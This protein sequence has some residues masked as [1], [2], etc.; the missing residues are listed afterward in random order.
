MID[1]LNKFRGNENHVSNVNLR[2]GYA[3]EGFSINWED[4]DQVFQALYSIN[5][6]LMLKA[7]FEL[8]KEPESIDLFAG[9]IPNLIN[10]MINFSN[11][12]IEYYSDLANRIIVNIFV[13]HKDEPLYHGKSCAY[14]YLNDLIQ[15][16]DGIDFLLVILAKIF[17]RSLA[18]KSYIVTLPIF[19]Q[20]INLENMNEEQLNNYVSILSNLFYE[21]YIIPNDFYYVIIRKLMNILISNESNIIRNKCLKAFK[22]STQDGSRTSSFISSNY[23]EVLL[24][25]FP[26]LDQEGQ[27]TVLIIISHCY[28]CN[29]PSL[30]EN[31]RQKTPLPFF[32]QFLENEDLQ[33]DTLI[34]ITNCFQNDTQTIFDAFNQ[35][36]IQNII[37]LL[38]SSSFALKKRILYCLSIT[39]PVITV[40]MQQIFETEEFIDELQDLLC[41]DDKE[42]IENIF[43]FIQIY[44]EK[45]NSGLIDENLVEDLILVFDELYD[46]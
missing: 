46:S 18:V 10:A 27:G 32:M 37:N 8:T 9:C 15:N 16:P 36:F 34:S 33:A 2:I 41:S 28:A 30:L 17:A 26:T 22:L 31:V 5:C 12:E 39:L 20:I 45:S 21:D 13:V 14:Q 4:T 3:E 44:K 24:N 40:E 1:S 25:L 7:L 23:I 43:P 42:V 29:I 11:H 35:E 6:G 38:H 19:Q